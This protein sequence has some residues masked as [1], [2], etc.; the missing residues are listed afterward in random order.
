VTTSQHHPSA[1][2]NGQ[3]DGAPRLRVATYNIHKGIGGVDRRYRLERIMETLA[4]CQADVVLL[5]EVDDGVPRSRHD[6]Q[7]DLLGDALE[8]KHR[9]YQPNVKLR[10]GHYGNAILSRFPLYDLRDIE[11]SV[12]LKKRRQALVAHCR[13]PVGE[14]SRSL[15]VF[16][17]HL[18]LAGYER[19]IQIRR[20]LACEVLS[21]AHHDTPVVAG[22]DFNDVWGTLGRRLLEPAGFASA[23][24]A[25][26]TFP[27][28]FP[29]RP[30]DRIFYRGGL[31]LDHSFASRT[32]IAQ[33]AS[34]HL[35][36]VA[37]FV[38]NGGQPIS[39]GA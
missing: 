36:L 32:Q 21:H 26:K 5:Q 24:L 12:P 3:S 9:A 25:V 16:N 20:F 27:A 31:T 30:L 15:L 22:G 1:S 38:V 19:T 4:H 33:Q 34:D 14:H 11:L 8:L 6:R 7:V 23:S 35:P 29:M 18:G 39:R 28:F 10:R 37:E 17:F 2:H 13:L